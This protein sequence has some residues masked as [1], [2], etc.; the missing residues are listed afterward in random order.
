M[1]EALKLKQ[2]QFE[3]FQREFELAVGPRV[4]E[5]IRNEK[6]LWEQEQNFLIIR[7]LSKLNEE[8]RG[9]LRG[10]NCHDHDRRGPEDKREPLGGT[11]WCQDPQE[12]SSWWCIQP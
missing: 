4:D 2:N 11:N 6:I 5:R 7:E 3:T 1:E 12:E 10:T 8:K 9:P